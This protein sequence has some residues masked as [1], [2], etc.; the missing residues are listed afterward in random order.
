MAA[1]FYH[2][3]DQKRV[4]R[5]LRDR[6]LSETEGRIFTPVLPASTFYPAEEYH[7]K[8]Y[9]QQ[10]SSLMEALGEFYPNRQAILDSA[11]AARLNGYLAA[12]LTLE[13]LGEAL[14]K[15]DD[16]PLRGHEILMN[17]VSNLR[18]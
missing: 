6:H 14:R 2:T 9:L 13:E 1:I 17:R 4:I 15:L 18:H 16:L 3:E 8:Y 7:Q 5:E 10:E 11:V 12:H